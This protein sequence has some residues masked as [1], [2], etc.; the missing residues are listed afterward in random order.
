M[1][2]DYFSP[3]FPL[4]IAASRRQPH[5]GVLLSVGRQQ[6]TVCHSTPDIERAQALADISRSALCYHIATKLVQRLQIRPIVHNKTASPTIARSCIRV[7]AAVWECGDG[8]IDTQSDRHTETAVT[9]IHFASSTT[10]SKCNKVKVFSIIVERRPVPL[11]RL[12]D[13]GAVKQVWRLAYCN[14][15][16]SP[17]GR[18]RKICSYNIHKYSI[19][20]K[21]KRKTKKTRD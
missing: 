20:N 13:T 12:V 4:F 19:N 17:K 8:Q 18:E 2:N 14:Q 9:T 7:R 5:N 1:W 16:Y 3:P 21:K 10:R 11:W 15:L 6:E